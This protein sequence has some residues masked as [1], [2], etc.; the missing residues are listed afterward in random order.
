MEEYHKVAQAQASG[1]FEPS[2]GTIIIC[3]QEANQ[4]MAR[5]DRAHNI[6]PRRLRQILAQERADIQAIVLSR[7]HVEA[8]S[9]QGTSLEIVKHG[10]IVR[11]EATAECLLDD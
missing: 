11:C 4:E 8:S 5:E 7:A 1:Y 3:G 2:A 6:M 10:R 9:R